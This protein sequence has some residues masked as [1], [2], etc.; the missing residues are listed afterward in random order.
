MSS[1]S[2]KI[3][4]ASLGGGSIEVWL[5]PMAGGSHFG[6]CKV[7]NTLGWETFAVSTCSMSASG[8][9]DVYLKVVGQPGSELMRIALLQFAS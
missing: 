3:E 9:H 4:A 8:T 2:L 7:T 1:T 6:P 5:D